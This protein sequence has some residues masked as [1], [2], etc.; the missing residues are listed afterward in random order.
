MK[1][2]SQEQKDKFIKAYEDL[3]KEH[4]F[5]LVPLPQWKQSMDT[6][7]WSLVTMLSIVELEIK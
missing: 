7:T 6:G 1:E 5:Q 2:F 3:C 4:G